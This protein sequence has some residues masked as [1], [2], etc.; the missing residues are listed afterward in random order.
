MSDLGVNKSTQEDT[1]SGQEVAKPS[2]QASP[3]RFHVDY[4]KERLYRK[5]FTKGGERHEVQ[6]WSVRLQHLGR[7]EAFALGSS[8]ASTAAS[9]AK[10]IFTYLEANGWEATKAKFKPKPV[11]SEEISTV[12]AFIADVKAHG[13]LKA[14]TLRR[15]AVKLRKM[16]ADLAQIEV[17]AKAKDR[18]AKYDY[19]NG[20]HA[21]WL[22]KV[23]SQHLDIL[24]PETINEWRNRYIAKADED[25]SAR[26]SAER[27]AASYVRCARALFSPE[28]LAVL[29]VRVP[30]NPFAGVKLKDPGSQ[31]YSS[32]IDV[33]ELNAAAEKDL[34]KE[35]GQRYLAFALCFW[36]GLRRK[37]ADLLLWEQVDLER[38]QINIRV[39]SVF[40]PKTP[41]SQ[42][43]VDLAAKPL[44]VLKKFK[45]AGKS[46]FV[47]IGREPRLDATYEYYRCDSTWRELISW[48]KKKG[49]RQK[50][51]IHMLRKESGSFIA[52]DYGIEATR[53]HLGHR[54]IRTTSAIYVE[55]KRRVEVSLSAAVSPA[56]SPS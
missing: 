11:K 51:P 13:H 33:G 24:T 6:E 30:Q 55:K 15:Y 40:V 29:K 49:S 10:D 2:G 36:A 32:D 35:G 46:R 38:G 37:E 41:E 34:T 16:V 25:P 44:A 42:R 26:M 39:T 52:A 8:N 53:Q 21:A 9:K 20:G 19:V 45:K 14:M 43:T 5:T 50:K 47:M 23:D 31:R 56:R 18:K 3:S 48:L 12:G 54:D 7:R 27:S 28:V 22:M 1:E 4:W 17:G